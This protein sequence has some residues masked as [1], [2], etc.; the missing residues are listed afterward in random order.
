MCLWLAT[1]L[2]SVHFEDEDLVESF[3]EWLREEAPWN[4]PSVPPGA[5]GVGF[6]RPLHDRSVP[7]GASKRPEALVGVG[8]PTTPM[9]ERS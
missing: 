7:W 4:G 2:L 9:S 5:T 3:S 1:I 6:L 8:L